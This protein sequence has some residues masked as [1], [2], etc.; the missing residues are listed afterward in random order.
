MLKAV[1]LLLDIGR[2]DDASAA[3]DEL[4]GQILTD[5]LEPRRNL[6]A[7]DL[8]LRRREPDR[9]IELLSALPAERFGTTSAAKLH[10][11][12]ARAYEDTG[13]FMDAA[14]ARDALD[15][16][17]SDDTRRATNHSALWDA[18]IRTDRTERERALTVAAGTLIGWL[19]LAEVLDEHRSAPAA[20]E[21]ALSR[22]KGKF[23][24]H[25]ANAEIVTAMLG[26][27]RATVRRPTRIA[28]LLPFHGDFAEAADATRG[29]FP[30]RLVCGRGK[31]AATGRRS[32]RHLVRSDRRRV[33]ARGR[34]G[35][36]LRRGSTS[37]RA[38]HVAGMRRHPPRHHPGIERD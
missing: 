22:W 38:G 24:N 26:A 33:R 6:L 29:R 20:L 36:G 15:A 13:R 16:A 11:L 32:P 5:D 28:L 1:A 9:T 10:L 21:R 30:R 2:T 31:R 18:L 3:L 25:P 34:G 19:R 17:L 4:S 35:C 7:A 14:R 23:P 12:R 37:A 8:A 27:L